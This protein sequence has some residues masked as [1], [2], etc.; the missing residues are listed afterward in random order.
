MSEKKNGRDFWSSKYG[1]ILAMAGNAVGLGNFLRFPVQAAE[2][3]GGAFMLPYIICF[4][5]I[6]IPLMWIEWG[7][8]RHAG[9]LG[10]GT[11]FGVS[12]ALN[13]DKGIQVFSLLGIWIP[14]IISIYY[15]YIE[16]WT[17]GY[18]LNFL[19]GN[20]E[21]GFTDIGMKMNF[22]KSTFADYIGSSE[23]G[24]TIMSPSLFAYSCF[25][26]TVF[27]NYKIISKGISKGIERFVKIAMP[28]LF[29]MS[30]F[31]VIY[32]L[33]LKTPVSSSING[34][35]FLWSPN[36]DYLFSPRVW[37]A[38]A[39][40]VFFTL[41]LG[42][43][44]IVTYASFVR[45]G[46]D[47]ALSGLTSASI[48]ELIEVV[49]GGSIVIPAAVAFLGVSG[50]VLV[51]QSGAFSIGFIA[52]PAIFDG[53]PFG[54]YIGFIWF[55]LLFIAGL[56]SSVG[57]LQ[58]VVT[59]VS[60][61]LNSYQKRSS[62]LV[63]FVIFIFAQC[64]IFFPGFLEEFDFWAGTIFLVV[65][66]LT[67]ILIFI[68]YIAPGDHVRTINLGSMIRVPNIFN[69]VFRYYLPALLAILFISWLIQDVQ[70]DN[71]IIFKFNFWS[72]LARIVLLGLFIGIFLL[73][74]KKV[75]QK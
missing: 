17:L 73:V 25:V 11:T 37:I 52:M 46:D 62:Q 71:S 68:L 39:G 28:A 57:I 4:I 33:T 14:L 54:S 30:I 69:Q 35:N 20:F 19:L 5:L 42:F 2:N 50:A 70:S 59:F 43:G 12:N 60:E 18:S 7:I 44:A 26:L 21:S 47:I 65:L 66:A 29:I 23:S 34:L 6:G 31:M 15:I 49:F 48:N 64:V 58:P 56:T 16:S 61:E 13:V 38:A 32:V 51:A 63:M 53:L 75:F 72:Q 67:E 41:S 74:A 1:L 40:Q 3:G 10:K 27:I 24:K 8:G 55:F 9:V 45:Q 22:F 36:L